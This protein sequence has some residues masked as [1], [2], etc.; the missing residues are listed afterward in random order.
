M[1]SVKVQIVLFYLSMSSWCVSMWAA[2]SHF[3]HTD[4]KSPSALQGWDY[5]Y[6]LAFYLL[7]YNN[8]LLL[9][10]NFMIVILALQ[11]LLA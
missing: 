7:F 10:Y 9:F 4:L 11:D 5:R 3:T 1:F 8:I 2:S 6:V